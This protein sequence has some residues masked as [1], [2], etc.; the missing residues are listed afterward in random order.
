MEINNLL[1]VDTLVNQFLDEHKQGI[2][3]VHRTHFHNE[4][5]VSIQAIIAEV[6]DELRTGCVTF[7]NKEDPQQDLGSYL[8][9]IVNAFCQKKAFTSVSFK[10]KTEYLCPGCLF[11]KNKNTVEI[12]ALFN[13]KDCESK[14]EQTTDPKSILLFKTFASHNKHGYRCS[15]CERFIPHPIDNSMRVTCPYL[16]C[17]FVGNW[18]SLKRMNHPTIQSNP[19]KL[20]LDA[21]ID[22]NSYSMKD[23]I[24]DEDIDS[25]SKIEVIEELNNKVT[26]LKEVINSQMS[27][28][29]YSSSEFTVHN[30][31]CCY[32]AFLELLDRYPVEM[33][34]YLLHASRSGGFQQKIFQE[35]IEILERSLP[36]SF[37][38]NGKIY[39]IESL[40]DEELSLF[41]G[42]SE[43]EG[44]VSDKLEV[45]NNTKEFYIGGRKASYTKPYYIGKLLSVYD[46]NTKESLINNVEEYGFS[47]LKMKDI[48]P[49]KEIVVTHLRIPPHYQMGGMVYVNRLRKK[50]VDRATAMIDNI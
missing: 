36:Y 29:A 13:C 6:M 40:L 4:N 38:K 43:F 39:K 12:G 27:S 8:F 46:K 33:V 20:I 3:T 24:A 28:V 34:D 32:Q 21:T 44:V 48:V 10:K 25:L 42:I 26:L 5:P 11:F 22:G 9:Y 1:D 31:L 35:Y 16:D 19:E 7:L 17:C 41:D 37:K 45:K 23:N 15:D 30:K 18:S 49:G 47:K 50:I 2:I 14:S